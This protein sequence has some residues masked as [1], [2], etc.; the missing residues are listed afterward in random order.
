MCQVKLCKYCNIEKDIS[1]FS[2]DKKGECGC[3]SKCKLCTS[4]YN[5]E[6]YLKNPSVA[7]E[8][9]KKW[10]LNNPDR[11]KQ[12]NSNYQKKKYNEDINSSREKSRVFN[13]KAWANKSEEDV[14]KLNHYSNFQ[15]LCSKINRDIKRG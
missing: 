8:N 13:R 7:K 12:I 5:R 10:V 9:A 11:R 15:P 4:K 3:Q 6:R 2:K 1:E 14:I